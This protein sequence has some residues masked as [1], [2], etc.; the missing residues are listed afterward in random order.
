MSAKPS[1]ADSIHHYA[2][3]ATQLMQT[4]GVLP[5]PHH[6]A[7]FY[8]LAAGQPGELV[9]DIEQAIMR[10]KTLDDVFLGQ[11]F[12]MHLAGEQSRA[13]QDAA[14]GARRILA[15][16]V[17]SIAGF[18][19][20]THAVSQEIS[21]KIASVENPMSEDSIQMLAK[22]VIDGALNM[23]STGES[24]TKQLAGAQSEI[25]EL[26]ENLAKATSE[27]ERDFL[28]GCFNR[29]AFDKRLQLAADEADT[30]ETE[31]TLIM[32]DIDYF[33][34]FNDEFGHLIGDEVLKV[35]ARGLTD[36]VK[37]IDTVA[38]Y[39]GEEFAIILPRTPV[40]GGMIVAESIRKMIASREF[41]NKAS[42]LSYGAIT[43]SL[44]VAAYRRNVDSPTDLVKRADTALYR[45][46]HAGRNRVTQENLSE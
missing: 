40:G 24:M 37:G 36:A 15:E 10:N 7:V 29:K 41:K 35:V 11:L 28:T 1:N 30:H 6:Y 32:I 8:A 17:Q 38:R 25:A 21:D 31:L 16:V 22:S 23:M 9:K 43:L 45:S 20:T 33:K 44:G 3:Q 39:G 26:R 2:A 13:V 4:H 18:T 34:K 27:S 5:T 46:K 14:S 12:D 19:G 42:G